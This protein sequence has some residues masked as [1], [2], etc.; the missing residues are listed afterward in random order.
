[1]SRAPC[2]FNEAPALRGGN[3][4]CRG[5]PA[6]RQ[7]WSFNEAP[8]LRGGNHYIAAKVPLRVTPFNEAPALRGGNRRREQNRGYAQALLQ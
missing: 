1:M 8:A 4:S 6:T 3:P 5:E 7:P 2:T